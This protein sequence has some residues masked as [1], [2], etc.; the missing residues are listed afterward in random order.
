MILAN[1][2]NIVPDLGSESKKPVYPHK[3]VFYYNDFYPSVVLWKIWHQGL[4][5]PG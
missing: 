5:K 1:T 3:P 2:G 4:A